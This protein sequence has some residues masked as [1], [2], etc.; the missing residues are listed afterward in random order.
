MLTA[1]RALKSSRPAGSAK[2]ARPAQHS[3]NAGGKLTLDF[4]N[5]ISVIAD[6]DTEMRDKFFGVYGSLTL[7]YSF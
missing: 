4:K 6:C 3:F 5:D 2:G 7:R 1:D